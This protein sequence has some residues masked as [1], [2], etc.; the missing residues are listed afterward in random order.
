MGNQM[1]FSGTHDYISSEN[2]L[3]FAL[4][5][6]VPNI[7]FQGLFYTIFEISQK[8]PQKKPYTFVLFISSNM[9]FNSTHNLWCVT[10]AVKT[11]RV[12]KILYLIQS[13]QD[14]RHRL[15]ESYTLNGIFYF[16][17]KQKS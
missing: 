13:G 4:R 11:L 3:D 10:T 12:Q 17:T 5:I 1:L 16:G 6:L 14:H 2:F 9:Y 8:A 7:N 15:S